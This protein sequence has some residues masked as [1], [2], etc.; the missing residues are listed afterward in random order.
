M[1]FFQ[2]IDYSRVNET[3]ARLL[4]NTFEVILIIT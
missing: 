3:D 2:K 1:K 4:D